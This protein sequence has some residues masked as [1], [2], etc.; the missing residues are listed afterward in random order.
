MNRL[1]ELT[2]L[3]MD[4]KK[5]TTKEIAEYFEVSPR[6]V[7][8]DLDKL[9]IAGVPIET[10]KGYNGGVSI[11]GSY[12]FSVDFMNEK[13][14]DLLITGLNAMETVNSDKVSS[15]IARKIFK[16][17]IVERPFIDID[18]SSWYG[19]ILISKIDLIKDCLSNSKKI[20]FTY[21]RKDEKSKNIVSPYQIVF[22]WGNWY[23]RGID[24]NGEFRLYKL[25]RMDDLKKLEEDLIYIKYNGDDNKYFEEEKYLLI[26]RFSK[27]VK[28]QLI[29]EY[30]IDSF[31]EEGDYLYFERNFVNKD[32]MLSWILSFGNDIVVLKPIEIKEELKNIID[33]MKLNY[34]YD[35]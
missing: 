9:L 12:K 10:T 25:N 17:N 1:F 22:R 27:K 7:Y 31:S 14:I 26:A 15:H 29:D 35:S 2:L 11:D 4:K 3:L 30:G 24:K 34:E 18:L 28:Y 13:E 21:Y 8:R 6:T 5:M 19:S 23:L 16:E 32:Y 20:S 33:L